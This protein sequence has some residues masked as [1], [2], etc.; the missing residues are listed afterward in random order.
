[1]RTIRS[2]NVNHHLCYAN[3]H[4]F[5]SFS[6]ESVMLLIVANMVQNMWIFPRTVHFYFSLK[7]EQEVQRDIVLFQIGTYL[8]YCI[9]IYLVFATAAPPVRWCSFPSNEQPCSTQL[10]TVLLFTGN[11]FHFCVWSR[12]IERLFILLP[13]WVYNMHPVTCKWDTPYMLVLAGSW[14]W[15]V[16]II[17]T[18]CLMRYFYWISKMLVGSY[19]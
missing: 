8:I 6:A 14:C 19:P 16:R 7:E 3:V 10:H 13:S 2:V 12:L 18:I 4:Q 5:Y 1:M 9:L 15:Y 11:L 17:K